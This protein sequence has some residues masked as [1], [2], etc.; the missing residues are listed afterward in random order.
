MFKIVIKRVDGTIAETFRG[1]EHYMQ[2]H[3]DYVR[4][5][6]ATASVEIYTNKGGNH[7]YKNKIDY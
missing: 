7:L 2:L 5:L 1:T 4:S 6:V 3:V